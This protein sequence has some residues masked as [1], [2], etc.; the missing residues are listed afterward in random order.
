MWPKGAMQRLHRLTVS[1]VVLAVTGTA[2]SAA[3]ASDFVV[4]PWPASTS[5][6]NATTFSGRAPK[7][8]RAYTGHLGIVGS[9]AAVAVEL[10]PKGCVDHV[11]VST[12]ARLFDCHLAINAGFFDF[13]PQAACEGNLVINT[14][15]VQFASA[16]ARA[17]IGF[18]ANA[19]T[20]VV[21]YLA[22]PTPGLSSLVS[23]LGWL[24]RNGASYVNSSREFKPSDPFVTE[25]APRTAI[26]VTG[27]GAVALLVVDGVETQ[28][29]GLSLFEMAD[30]L[31]QLGIVHAINLD[32]GGSSDA[33]LD[34]K[35]WSRP[36][37]QDTPTPICERN[38]TS[39]VCVR[40]Y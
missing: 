29:I 31:I 14:T 39:V 11:P 10:P 20:T 18:N 35:V 30:V 25:L 26:G 40:Y 1:A 12:S 6:L 3:A 32:G 8:G 19:R 15:V 37:C 34:G 21:G 13:P 22:A 27:S 38:V 23:G 28:Q 33:V 5:P 9:P 36:T 4:A 7:T 17:S 2:V 16:D 24:V